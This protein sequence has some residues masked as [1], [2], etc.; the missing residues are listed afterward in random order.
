MAAPSA[1]LACSA[2]ILAPSQQSGELP[3]QL[4]WPGARVTRG[5]ACSYGR[6]Q[7]MKQHEHE[8]VINWSP[9]S[10]EAATVSGMLD[11]TRG[12]EGR[13]T[14]GSREGGLSRAHTLLWLRVCDSGGPS[15]SRQS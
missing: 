11:H 10:K 6:Q 12:L 8:G 3:K 1:P 9:E 5:S 13:A 4:P 15:S 7:A 2:A 14:E